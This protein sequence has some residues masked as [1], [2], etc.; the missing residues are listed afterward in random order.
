MDIDP[1]DDA[2]QKKRRTAAT[3]AEEQARFAAAGAEI[4]QNQFKAVHLA[5]CARLNLHRDAQD[6]AWQFLAHYLQ[7]AAEVRYRNFRVLFN[8]LECSSG[9]S[10]LSGI[11]MD[12]IPALSVWP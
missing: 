4:L 5:V 1:V 12:C 10:R 9:K 3:D 11:D 8:V 2:P 6:K 7:R